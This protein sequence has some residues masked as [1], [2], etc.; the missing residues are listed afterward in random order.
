MIALDGL[1]ND[2]VALLSSTMKWR[3]SLNFTSNDRHFE[4]FLPPQS[5]LVCSS[6]PEPTKPTTAALAAATRRNRHR[7]KGVGGKGSGANTHAITG[8][9]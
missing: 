8:Q 1:E 5:I 4:R 2:T 9:A 6:V 3:K 7:N